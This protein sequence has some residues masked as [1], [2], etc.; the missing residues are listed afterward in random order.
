ME[1]FFTSI[2]V[3]GT[4]YEGIQKMVQTSRMQSKLV[5]I[6]LKCFL[7]GSAKWTVKN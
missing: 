2:T 6:G 7:T 1:M 4:V 5:L 3:P